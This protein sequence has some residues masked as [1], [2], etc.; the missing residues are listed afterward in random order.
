MR[1]YFVL[2]KTKILSFKPLNMHINCNSLSKHTKLM[3][4]K[5]KAASKLTAWV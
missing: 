5:V 1:R 2:Y 3:F 4:V